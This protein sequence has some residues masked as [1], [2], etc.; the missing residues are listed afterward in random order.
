MKES[1]RPPSLGRTKCTAA[2]AAAAATA[3]L[4]APSVEPRNADERAESSTGDEEGRPGRTLL[5]RPL[6]GCALA[7]ALR[8]L[9]STVGMSSKRSLPSMRPFGDQ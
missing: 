5:P 1:T 2:T 4:E 3:R 8:S 6:G 9:A 7:A